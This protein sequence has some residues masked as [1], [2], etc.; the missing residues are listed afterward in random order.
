MSSPPIDRLSK[1]LTSLT[2]PSPLQYDSTNDINSLSPCSPMTFGDT[3]PM[4]SDQFNTT[5]N[6]ETTSKKNNKESI[7]TPTKKSQSKISSKGKSTFVGSGLG[8]KRENAA[9]GSKGSAKETLMRIMTEFE[10]NN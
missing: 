8:F 6:V 3:T 1:S 10:A 2:I 4:K 5:S 9:I 7:S